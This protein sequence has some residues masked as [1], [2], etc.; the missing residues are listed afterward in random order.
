MTSLC[1]LDDDDDEV[2][3]FFFNVL[4]FFLLPLVAVVVENVV[5]LCS[6]SFRFMVFED[7][8]FLALPVVLVG[9]LSSEVIST[10]VLLSKETL[11]TCGDNDDGKGKRGGM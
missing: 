8:V 11:L 7:V 3:F 10:V 4:D 1:S 6:S 5:L 9:L 2:D